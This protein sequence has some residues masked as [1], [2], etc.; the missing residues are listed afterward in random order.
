MNVRWLIETG[1]FDEYETALLRALMLAGAGFS[2]F[3]RFSPVENQHIDSEDCVIFRGSIDTAKRLIKTA[4]FIPGVYC[5]FK[6][7]NCT[8]YYP[9]L[10]KYLL[11]GKYIM[12]PFGDLPRQKDFLYRT[13]AKAD[14]V[15]IRPSRSDKPF[16]GRLVHADDFDKFLDE[17]SY[18]C[19][20]GLEDVVVVAVPKNVEA[21][22][23][24]VVVDGKVI[25][26]CQYSGETTGEGVAAWGLASEI[27]TIYKPDKVF[28]IDI[29]LADQGLALLELN[30]FSCAGLYTC[31]LEDVVREVSRVALEEWYS[32]A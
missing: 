6:N 26:G 24:L 10:G 7:Y 17:V 11:N 4:K 32:Y 12:L 22:F 16:T 28:T 23:R 31:N 29:C 25:A 19:M 2:C 9:L 14:T 3:N 1:V 27:A 15:F 13:I 8:N 21:E 18:S 30:S 20:V 5:N